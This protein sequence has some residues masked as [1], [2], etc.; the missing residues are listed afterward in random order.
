MAKKDEWGL[1]NSV[2]TFIE[3]NRR[4]DLKLRDSSL[5]TN[6]YLN[7][8]VFHKASFSETE[9]LLLADVTFSLSVIIFPYEN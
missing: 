7:F 1:Q 5:I 4:I 6:T 2:P 3:A 8:S 9:W